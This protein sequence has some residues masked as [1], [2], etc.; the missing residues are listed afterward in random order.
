MGICNRKD[1][2][3]R[4]QSL[5]DFVFMLTPVC[6]TAARLRYSIEEDG[7]RFNDKYENP[8]LRRASLCFIYQDF[9]FRPQPR[10]VCL[11][12]P[13]SQDFLRKSFISEHALCVNDVGREKTGGKPHILYTLNVESIRIC[14]EIREDSM[15]L[16][17]FLPNLLS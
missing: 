9:F 17:H 13:S 3:L 12:A 5:V 15:F 10:S 11:M 6:N 14:P 2:N 7:I 16:N 8:R 4:R 1:F